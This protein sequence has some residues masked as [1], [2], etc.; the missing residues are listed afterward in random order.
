MNQLVSEVEELRSNSEVRRLKEIIK[1]EK[2][3]HEAN[4]DAAVERIV[5]LEESLKGEKEKTA[6]RT[7]VL[8][9]IGFMFVVWCVYRLWLM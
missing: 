6:N 1:A 7:M 5:V 3:K 2:Q 8:Q 9:V 4:V